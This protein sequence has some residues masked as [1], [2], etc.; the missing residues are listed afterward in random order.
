MAKSK[1]PLLWITAIPFQL[2]FDLPP[3]IFFLVSPD[4][5]VWTTS[6]LNCILLSQPPGV[7]ENAPVLRVCSV[8]HNSLLLST[9]LCD[10]ISLPSALTLILHHPVYSTLLHMAFSQDLCTLSLCQG[11]SS[12]TYFCKLYFSFFHVFV[13]VFS[14]TG[15]GMQCCM[16]VRWVLRSIPLSPALSS[17]RIFSTSLL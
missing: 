14:S 4:S 5:P 16:H 7:R 12:F 9:L 13:L 2:T 6:N 15:D 11:H 8:S 10:L 1:S 17:Y 3:T